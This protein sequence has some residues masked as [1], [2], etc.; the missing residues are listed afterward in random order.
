M[1][2]KAQPEPKKKGKNKAKKPTGPK[3]VDKNLRPGIGHNSNGQVIPGVVKKVDEL[4]ALNERKKEIGKA[5]RDIRNSLKTEFGIL[6]GPLAHE[7]RL[8]KMD[9]DVRVQFE[10]AHKDLKIALGYQ[11]ELDFAGPI[12]TQAS[13]KAQPSEGELRKFSVEAA[14]ETADKASAHQQQNR[15][16]DQDEDAPDVINREG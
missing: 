3:L 7:I 10:S 13:L 14:V 8:R 2:D 4:I 16:E 6:S 15:E 9:S 1:T 5:E 11:P 12:P